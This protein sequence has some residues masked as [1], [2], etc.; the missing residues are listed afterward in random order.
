MSIAIFHLTKINVNSL[1]ESGKLAGDGAAY[2][3]LNTA[4]L[5]YGIVMI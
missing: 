3:R 4:R 2:R 1:P 5:Q